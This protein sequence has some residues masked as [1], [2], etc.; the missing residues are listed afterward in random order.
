MRYRYLTKGTLPTAWLALWML[1]IVSGVFAQTSRGTVSGAIADANGAVITG[2]KVELINKATSVTRSTTTNEAGIYRFDAVDL[3]V[4]ELKV[5]QTGFRQFVASDITVEANRTV[6]ID[7]ALQV[8]VAEQVVEVSATTEALLTKDAPIRGGNLSAKTV[9]TLPISGLEPLSIARTLPGVVQAVGSSTFGNGGQ[10][11]N[12]SVNGQRPRG[13]NYL[14]DG[15][16]NND[17]SIGGNA[18]AFSIADAVQEVSVQTS[19]FGAEFG[20]GGGGVFNVITKGGTNEIHGTVY[21]QYRSQIFNSQS[22]VNKLNNVPLSVF[23]QNIFGFTVGGPIIKNKTFAFGG[24]QRN[25]F[26]STNNY[27]FVIPTDAAVTRLRAL[28]SNNPR[29]NLYLNAIGS[30]RGTAN[31]VTIALGPDAANV[32]RGSVQ[33][34]T[35]VVGLASP[36]TNTQWL[37]RLDHS[38]SERHQI[39]GRYTSNR[40]LNSPSGVNF[41]GYIFDSVGKSQNFLVS[42]T[43]TINSNWTNEFRFSFGQIKFDFPIAESKSVPEAKT[44][45]NFS[46]PNVSTPGIQTNI[47]Q[48]RHADNYLFQGTQTYI[49]GKHTFRYGFEFLKQVAQQRPPFVERGAYTYTNVGTTYSGFVNFLEDF[50]GP[51]GSASRNFGDPIYNPNLFRHSYFIQDTWKITPALSLTPGLRYENFGQPANSA[52]KFP[53]YAGPDPAQFTVPNQVN[54][55]NNNFGPSLGL[56]WSPAYS[57][58]LMG[59]LFGDRKMVVRGGYQVSYDTFFNNLLSNMAADTPNTINTIV[60]GASTGRGTANWLAALPTTAR[61]PDAL[62]DGQ[63]S[64]FDKNIRS[65][66]TQRWSLGIQRELPG[67]MKFDVSYVG[68]GSHKL[69]TNEDINYRK[70]DNT[71]VYPALGVRRIRSSQGNANYHGLQ[72]QLDKRFSKGLDFSIA[73]GFSRSIDST[74]EV[75]N[76]TASVS[77]TSVPIALGGLKLDRGLSDYHRKHRF[78]IAYTYELPGP[79]KGLLHY[80][81]G[82]WAVSGITSFQSGAPYTIFNGFDRNNDGNATDR[83][84][85]GNP[86]A[87]INTRAVI[88]A[89]TVCSTGFRNPDT[90]ACVNRGD[91]RWVQ[92]TGAPNAST[93][94]RN[95]LFTG[96]QKNWDMTIFKNFRVTETKRLE[97]R[98]EA[99]NIFN[100]PQF[101]NVPSANVVTSLGPSTGRASRFLNRDYTNSGTRNMWVQAKFLF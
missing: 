85:I 66:Y 8:G 78:T 55:D 33:F 73:Y 72:T 51:S 57:S 96:A 76:T 10:N 65:P 2:A 69:F 97:L 84:D 12:F 41:P 89:A 101:F 68:T 82:G 44:L 27:S 67:R 28:F 35:V 64:V 95:T 47:P 23:N 99:F 48:F 71:R 42:D 4:Y 79:K 75:F 6:T 1:I 21:E 20:R 90:Q 46:I 7:A 3:G 81:F 56:A 24:Y 40:S 9:T 58:G 14:L 22:N 45:P 37:T 16:E 17:I 11:V 86:N 87:P 70:A 38:F 43:Y 13:N 18:Q 92:G 34:G 52:F 91:V 74:S 29:L 31:P 60:N 59:R 39:A 30:L 49:A 100:N 5:G 77:L 50:S 32:D 80:P 93:V 54:S 94:G 88:V 62:R 19:N 36:S 63:T 98:L 26:R 25:M 15:T 83:P 53:A 61:T